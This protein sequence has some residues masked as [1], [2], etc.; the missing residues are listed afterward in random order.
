M[1][2]YSFK[3]RF[4]EPIIDGSKGGTIRADRKRHAR[5]GETIQ[6]YTGMRTRNCRLIGSRTCL[7][8]E[9][10]TLGLGRYPAVKL[11]GRWTILD[12]PRLTLFAQFDG[13][14]D[15][16]EL[17]TFWFAAHGAIESFSG[18]HIRWLPLPADLEEG[19]PCRSA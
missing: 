14:A 6:L 13:F 17:L 10:I 19:E 1:V 7:A 12:G 5:P 3:E 8:V 16:N 15:W 11:G 4:G 2:A 18:M 9:P